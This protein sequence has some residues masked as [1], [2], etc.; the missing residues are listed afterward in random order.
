MEGTWAGSV[1]PEGHPALTPGVL[2]LEHVAGVRS[3][4]IAVD[5]LGRNLYWT[6]GAAGQVLATRLEA[7]W[8]GT[9]EYTV[10]M[11]GDLDRPHS[12]VLQPLAGYVWNKR[13][14]LPSMLYP[15]F[16]HGDRQQPREE[17]GWSH[18]GAVGAV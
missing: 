13:T 6:D 5:W 4:C 17:L 14:S 12:I 7:A 10:V 15:I 16:L 3:D 1:V 18:L 11:D 2:T 9:P 8:R